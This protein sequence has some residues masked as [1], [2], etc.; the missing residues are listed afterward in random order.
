M[1]SSEGEEE[2]IDL[3]ATFAV[4]SPVAA[5]AA[6]EPPVTDGSADGIAAA[7]AGADQAGSPALPANP[8]GEPPPPGPAVIP[9]Q[10]DADAFEVNFDGMGAGPA[11]AAAAPTPQDLEQL[12]ANFTAGFSYAAR[13]TDELALSKGDLLHVTEQGADGWFIGVNLTSGE[14]GTFPGNFVVALAPTSPTSGDAALAARL[15]EE[16]NASAPALTK[17][18]LLARQLQEEED[19]QLAMRAQREMSAR[20]LHTGPGRHFLVARANPTTHPSQYG[21]AAAVTTPSA[22]DEDH[23][24][25]HSILSGLKN[26][27]LLNCSMSALL[28]H[29][30]HRLLCRC[31]LIVPWHCPTGTSSCFTALPHSRCMIAFF[32]A[33]DSIPSIHARECAGAA[34]GSGFQDGW[35]P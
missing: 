8:F 13:E 18:G 32:F 11:P 17:D 9:G 14:S 22:A 10:V 12:Q 23:K 15:Q 21:T 30:P 5:P 25:N 26:P 34:A 19:R 29:S 20:Q 16:E 27:V 33:S 7:A 6:S 31:T 28:R 35:C 2:V 3:M 24:T 1:S 4:A